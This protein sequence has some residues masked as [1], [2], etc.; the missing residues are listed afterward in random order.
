MHNHRSV[1]YRCKKTRD[2]AVVSSFKIGFPMC[3]AATTGDLLRNCVIDEILGLH[4]INCMLSEYCTITQWANRDS[5]LIWTPSLIC[6]LC[7]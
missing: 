2:V 7:L 3:L 5:F 1:V 4:K 6:M